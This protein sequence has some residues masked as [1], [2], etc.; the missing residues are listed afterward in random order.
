MYDDKVLRS[1]LLE[2]AVAMAKGQS[3]IEI[4][5]D[6][7]QSVSAMAAAFRRSIPQIVA[8]EVQRVS[9]GQR[10]VREFAAE[11]LRPVM[12]PPPAF[13]FVV[14]D[15]SRNRPRGELVTQSKPGDVFYVVRFRSRLLSAFK[16]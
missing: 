3:E 12:E 10:T 7:T 8:D 13:R 6:V 11:L 5:V 15:I 4:N 9:R 2:L 16:R 1:A 14:C